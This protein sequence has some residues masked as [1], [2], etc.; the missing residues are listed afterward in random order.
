MEFIELYNGGAGNISLTGLI[1]VLYSGSDDLSY[2][3]FDLDGFS[4]NASGYFTI[5]NAAV[6]GVDLVIPDGLLQDGADAVAM[7]TSAGNFPNGTPV[8]TV[9]GK[10]RF[11]GHINEVLLTRLLR[12]EARK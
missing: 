10:V 1:V 2:A 7:Y 8:V 3:S 4:T 5:G 6:P 11:R 12:A 9:D